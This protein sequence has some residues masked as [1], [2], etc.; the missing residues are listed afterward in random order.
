MGGDADDCDMQPVSEF[1]TTEGGTTRAQD[2]DEI[3]HRADNVVLPH[4]VARID[5]GGV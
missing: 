4:G 5:V 3:R 2:R 1:L